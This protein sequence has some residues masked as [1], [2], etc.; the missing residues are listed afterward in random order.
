MP[1]E[2]DRR[3]PT[4]SEI[5]ENLDTHEKDELVRYGSLED[6]LG[7]I[8][9]NMEEMLDMWKGAKGVLAF[10]KWA[11]AVG[12]TIAAIGLWVKDHLE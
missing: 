12:S 2:S 4:T 6:R 8:E 1:S 3:I 7:N 9:K 10:L 11:A 5:L